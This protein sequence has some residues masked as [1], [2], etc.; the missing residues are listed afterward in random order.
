MITYHNRPIRHGTAFH[1]GKLYDFQRDRSIIVARQWPDMRAWRKTPKGR[2]WKH[3][4]PAMVLEKSPEGWSCIWGSRESRQ[5]Y[6][7]QAGHIAGR[8]QEGPDDPVAVEE[9]VAFDD[10]GLEGVFEFEEDDEPGSEHW[11]KC[12]RLDYAEERN[13]SALAQYLS[14]IPEEI[15][16]TV[17]RF[18]NRHWH[19]LNLA[20]RCPGA[21]DLM[22]S[23]PALALALSSPWVFRE[24]PPSHPLRSAR[25]LLRKRQTEIAAWLGFPSA[26]STVKILRKLPPGECTVL[27][28]L[29]LRNLFG[30]HLKTLQHLTYLNGSIINLL[31][32]ER[33][34]YR[35]MPGFLEEITSRPGLMDRALQI[36]RD[37]LWMRKKLE[38]P[39]II[40][41]RSFKQLTKTHDF[42]VDRL[43][44]I[45]LKISDPLPFPLAPLA[46]WSPHMELEPLQTEMDLLEEGRIQKNC[47][48]AY[49]PR[50]Q[51]GKLYLYRLLE[52]ERATLAVSMGHSGKWELAEIKAYQ[53]S[54][55]APETLSS[56]REWIDCAGSL[57]SHEYDDENVPF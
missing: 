15:L 55:V 13:R 3:I 18:A 49:G 48:G 24:K 50:V 39:G 20:G 44:R 30:T 19:L 41:L 34:R 16:T 27:N 5:P 53:N 23:T 54:E 9:R 2:Q 35:T 57:D 21:F 51:R 8:L 17:S 11:K 42:L 37:T 36:L 26:W 22:Q 56:V 10:M 31:S 12:A 29:H 7:R 6:Q 45:D 43:G 52:P 25:S 38:D 14:P 28:L 46:A 4:R 40:T 1:D 33:D 47:V 32:G